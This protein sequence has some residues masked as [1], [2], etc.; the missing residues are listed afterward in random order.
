MARRL[1]LPPH[2]RVVTV[3]RAGMV[4]A[5]KLPSPAR[6]PVDELIVP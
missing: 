3:L 5:S 2:Q 1:N 6:L 4:D